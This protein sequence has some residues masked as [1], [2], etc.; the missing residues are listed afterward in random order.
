[1]DLSNAAAQH[2]ILVVDDAED[3]LSTLD[4]ALAF[5]PSV[6]V[7]AAR[8]AEDA[9]TILERASRDHTQVAAVVTDI[10][11]PRMS[12][13]DLIAHIRSQP[14]WQGL[15][16]VALSADTDPETPRRALRM[17]ADAYFPKPF[18]PG[19]VRR[20]LEELIHA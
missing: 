10:H 11:L 13:L 14:R 5:L 6:V 2:L 4:L 16:I 7:R 20:K 15:P 8:S 9:V 18:S 3:C 12:G 1:M 17:G 19:A